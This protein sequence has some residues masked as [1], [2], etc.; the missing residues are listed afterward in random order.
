MNRETEI[1]KRRGTRVLLTV[2]AIWGLAVVVAAQTGIYK[3]IYPLVLAYHRLGYR[4][5]PSL[6]MQC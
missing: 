2:L 1:R 4:G 3:A 5:C 6:S